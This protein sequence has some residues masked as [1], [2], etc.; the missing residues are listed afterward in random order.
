MDNE[1]LRNALGKIGAT[2]TPAEKRRLKLVQKGGPTCYYLDK[3]GKIVTNKQH[4]GDYL[5]KKNGWKKITKEK[6]QSIRAEAKR[7][8]A[9]A[10]RRA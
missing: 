9:E 5:A 4:I 6:V 7:V 2:L 10:K 1:L 3:N 8:K